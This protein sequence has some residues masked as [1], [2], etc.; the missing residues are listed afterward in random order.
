MSRKDSRHERWQPAL[1]VIHFVT[2]C[3]ECTAAIVLL[4]R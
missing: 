3:L 2:A 4:F 1:E